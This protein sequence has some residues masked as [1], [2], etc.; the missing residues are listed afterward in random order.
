M[1]KEFSRNVAD[2]T[3]G[4]RRQLMKAMNKNPCNLQELSAE[5]GAHN[6]WTTSQ[7]KSEFE[8]L[9]FMSPF[10]AVKRKSDGIVGSLAFQH[11][12]R[13]YF[14]FLEDAP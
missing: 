1:P 7:L 4:F 2:V 6:V 3:E 14:N 10:I 11:S 5:Y 13:F 9:G 8:V 12:P